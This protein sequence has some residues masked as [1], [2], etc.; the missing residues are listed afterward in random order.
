M[1]ATHVATG[2]IKETSTCGELLLVVWMNSFAH[3]SSVLTA[4]K[5]IKFMRETKLW[6]K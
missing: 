5:P 1:P 2:C 6:K 3:V 4:C